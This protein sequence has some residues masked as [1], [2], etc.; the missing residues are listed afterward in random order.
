MPFIDTP[1]PGLFVFEPKVFED[2]RGYFFESFNA[3]VFSEK[4]INVN[5]VQDNQSKSTYGI[6]RELHYQLDPFAQAKLVRVISGEVLDVAVDVRKGSPTFGQH[7]G[8][9]LSAENKKQLYI[10]R[11][12]AH[13]FVVLSETA[14]FFYKCD[15]FY[16]KEHDAG[17][18]YNDETLNIDWKINPADIKVSEKDANLP[19][20]PNALNNFQY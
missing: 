18:L 14:E 12:F 6:L 19:T 5:F 7:F 11:G 3:A 10:P 1:I 15:N 17:I 13:G 4:G 2:A 20:F 8:I 16:S 9:I